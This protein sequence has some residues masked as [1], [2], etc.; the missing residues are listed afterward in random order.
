[1]S[2][3]TGSVYKKSRRLSFSVLETGE[4]SKKRPYGPGQHGQDRKRKPS[5]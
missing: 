1:M 5:E 3:Y 4:E 2:R